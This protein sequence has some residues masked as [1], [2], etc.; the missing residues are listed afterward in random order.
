[1]VVKN[2]SSSVWTKQDS[3]SPISED[4]QTQ[5]VS[6]QIIC[7]RRYCDSFDVSA[8]TRRTKR[9]FTPTEPTNMGGS[10]KTW[11]SMET[12]PVSL[13]QPLARRRTGKELFKQAFDALEKYEEERKQSII[14]S[15]VCDDSEL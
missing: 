6:P 15:Q 14:D 12:V 11:S 10:I 13:Q 8:L 5:N 3:L 4:R 7:V 9:T 2:D 1:M